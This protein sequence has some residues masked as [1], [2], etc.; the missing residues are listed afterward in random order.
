MTV[1]Q[2]SPEK[3]EQAWRE[4]PENRYGYQLNRPPFIVVGVLL[5][6]FWGYWWVTL[7]TRGFHIPLLII[8]AILLFVSFYVGWLL[9]VWRHFGRVSGVVCSDEKML[10]RQG[11][12]SYSAPWRELTFDSLGLLKAEQASRYEQ[13]LNVGDQKL[14]L[15]RSFVR[16][17]HLESFV[18]ELLKRIEAHGGLPKKK[19]RKK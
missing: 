18:G 12:E 14:F 3:F 1:E 10:W 11:N 13:Y 17:R 4:S 5:A 8:G 16:L 15:F 19:K 2:V 7:F 6:S 9:L